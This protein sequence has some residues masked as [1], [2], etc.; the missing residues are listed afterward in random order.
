MYVHLS[1]SQGPDLLYT[2]TEI[3]PEG[4][5]AVPFKPEVKMTNFRIKNRLLAT[6]RRP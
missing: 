3:Q 6:P 4:M 2:P 5:A 1:Q